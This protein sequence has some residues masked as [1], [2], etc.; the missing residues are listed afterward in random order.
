M[1]EHDRAFVAVEL[2]QRGLFCEMVIWILPDFV[3]ENRYSATH[4]KT[5][6][7]ANLMGYVRV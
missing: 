5:V 2:D 6:M 1:D 3:T 7:G 4:G